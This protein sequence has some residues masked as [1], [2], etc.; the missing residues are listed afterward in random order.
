MAIYTILLSN[1]KKR[2]GSF[3]SIFILILIISMTL[4]TVVSVITSGKERFSIANKEANSPDIINIFNKEYYS[5]D[6]K[7]KLEKVEEVETVETSDI[8]SYSNFEVGDKKYSSF[9]FLSPY[10][11]NRNSYNLDSNNKMKEPKDGEIYLPTYFKEEFNCEVG[12]E[13]TFKTEISSYKYKIADFFEDPLWGGSMMGVKR[14]FVN[15]RE[16]SSLLK[17]EHD[18]FVKLIIL[19]TFIKDIYKENNVNEAIK[20]INEETGIENLGESSYTLG[21]FER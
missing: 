8:I 21:Q 19:D 3:I 13:I 5:D 10:N 7:N 14:F 18:N 4:T 15:N 12:Q 20:N 11:E 9:I 16:L 2:K 17:V 1:L 6:I